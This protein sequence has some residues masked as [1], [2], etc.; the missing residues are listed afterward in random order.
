MTGER[1]RGLRVLLATDDSASARVG[2]EWV[3]R[4]RYVDRPVIDVL[5]VAGRGMTRLGWGM[6][7]YRE[8]VRQAVEGLRAGELHEAERIANDVG[9]RLQHA[10]LTVH[11]WA[12][13]GDT[14]EEILGMA[15]IHAPDLVVVGP[16]GR[17]GLAATILGSVTH[18]VI[19]S[20]ERPVLVARPAR[21]PDG[22]LPEHA[23]LAVDGMTAAQAA[24][25]W[26]ASAGWLD[27]GRATILGLLGGRAGLGSHD[28]TAMD[29]L[30]G[31]LEAE[32]RNVLEDLAR[33]LAD[34]NV[35][36]DV[37]LR[38]GHPLEATLAAIEELG[39]DLVAVARPAGRSAHD[40]LP[41][42]IARHATASVLLVPVA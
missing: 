3:T 33:P 13:Q 5:C 41:Q 32:A 37:V 25:A 2:E 9:E 27:G 29:E 19:A 18:S 23:L 26:L 1:D 21:V 35:A 30:S 38:R 17:S 12:R 4:L 40:P 14:F 36:I 20:S 42:K 24:A 10:G 7:T 28:P 6:Q 15:S 34:G 8:P 39:V 11:T 31:L 16:R 22:P